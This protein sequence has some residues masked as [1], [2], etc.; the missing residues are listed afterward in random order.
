MKRTLAFA[1][2]L[3]FGFVT[4]AAL[5]Q[6]TQPTP[7]SSMATEST[8]KH[9]GEGKSTK[10]KT[11]TVVGTV[12][13]YEAGKKIVVVGPKKKDY[14]FDL[15][16]NAGVT[17]DIAAGTKVKVTYTKDESGQKVTTVAPY[18]AKKKTSKKAA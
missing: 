6:Q 9:K 10:V 18:A 2:G 4:V 3:A 16:Q 1:V 14:S 12:K 17:G 15:D 13:E 11:Q 7:G 8:T 5:A